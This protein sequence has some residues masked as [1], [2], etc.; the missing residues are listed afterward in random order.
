MMDLKEAVAKIATQARCEPLVGY[1]EGARYP[2]LP[3]PDI[4]SVTCG[5]RGG[6]W[7]MKTLSILPGEGPSGTGYAVTATALP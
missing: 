3:K 5:S 2:H 7:A 1:H 6:G 4:L